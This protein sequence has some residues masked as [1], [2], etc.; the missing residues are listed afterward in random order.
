M[1]NRLLNEVLQNQTKKTKLIKLLQGS[2]KHK[3]KGTK[4]IY[5]IYKEI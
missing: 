4:K 1:K 5:E 2:H 3:I